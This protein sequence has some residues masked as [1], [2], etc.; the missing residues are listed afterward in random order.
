MITDSSETMSTD[1]HFRS[2]HS[3]V[4]LSV[5]PDVAAKASAPVTSEELLAAVGDPRFYDLVHFLN[6]VLYAD[7]HPTP[8]KQTTI[9]GG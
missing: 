3:D 7:E 1:V 8:K 2:G 5:E 9:A 6:M 4:H